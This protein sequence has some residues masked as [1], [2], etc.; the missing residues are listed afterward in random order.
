MTDLAND[1]FFSVANP[2]SPIFTDPV[3]PVI[4]MLSHFKSR[5]IIGG[6][7]ECRKLSPFKIWRHHD[8]R[9]FGLIFLNRRKYLKQVFANQ[10]H[11]STD[12]VNAP[13]IAPKQSRY[14]VAARGTSKYNRKDKMMTNE[15]Y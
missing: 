11:T 15:L 13:R 12:R 2:K 4:N 5:W 1:L 3:V 10:H 7:R 8:F 6:L 9:T 14:N